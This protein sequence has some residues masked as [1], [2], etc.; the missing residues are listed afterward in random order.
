MDTS[1]NGPSRGPERES[2]GPRRRRKWPFVVG[3]LV[4]LG[5]VGLAVAGVVLLLVA[6]RPSVPAVYDEEWVAGDGP[7][8]IAVVPVEGVIAP[9]DNTMGGTQPT[10]TPDGLADAL[11][12]AGSDPSVVAV[13]IEVNSPGGGVTA[14]DEM[15][16]S[17]LNFRKNTG[18]PVVVSMGDTAASGGYY[19]AA[20]AD[21]ILANETTLT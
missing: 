15:H 19:I 21:R 6:S 12:Q 13:V 20:A 8:V 1:S 16:Q 10:T 9:A 17:I 14:S 5:L 4:A 11:R 7:D 18:K 3:G 2:E